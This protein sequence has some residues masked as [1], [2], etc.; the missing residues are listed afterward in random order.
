M[1]PKLSS[2]QQAQL[3]YL[4]LLPPKFQRIYSTIEQLA[5]PRVDETLMRALGRL[6]DDIKGNAASLSMAGLAETAG[7]M[8]MVVRGG[9]GIPTKVRGLRE[10]QGSLKINYDAAM[11]TATTP[12]ALDEEE[13]SAGPPP[14]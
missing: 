6:V 9:G 10:L 11:R 13:P 7:R 4:T 5:L 2:R 3:A 8:G 1:A 14:V 12:G